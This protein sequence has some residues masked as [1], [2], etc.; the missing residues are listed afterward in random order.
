VCAHVLL[1]IAVVVLAVAAGGERAQAQPHEPTA[2]PGPAAA[3]AQPEHAAPA[4]GKQPAGDHA[5]AD[6]HAKGEAEE[7][8]SVWQTIAKLFNFAIL[9]GVLVYYLK[10]PVA[11]YLASRSTQIRQDLITA[12]ETRAT[13][14]AELAEIERRLKSLPAELEA[15]KAQGV[16]DV[17]A[18]KVRIAQAAAVA[19][20]RLLDQTRREIAMH[21]RVA[22]REL[23]DLAADLTVNVARTR[24][25]RAITPEDQIRLVDRYTSQLGQQKE[26][27]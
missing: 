8:V 13:A 1:A 18:E 7:H 9:V 14:S 22:R 23:V 15:L 26:A 24:V 6:D 19:R 2:A 3:S 5:A 21:L 17:K 10:T 11:S 25:T 27:R 20:E 12:A 4:G 16:E